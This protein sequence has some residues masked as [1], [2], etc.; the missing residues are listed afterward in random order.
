MHLY[1]I[2]LHIHSVLR[3]FVL[4]FVILA[5]F[6]SM[7]G[8]LLKYTYNQLDKTV[9][10][11]ALASFHLQV[12][13]GILLYFLSPKI[14][15]HKAMFHVEMLRF[16]TIEHSSMMILSAV[17]ITIGYSRS[18]KSIG[19]DRKGHQQIL[20]FYLVALLIVLWAIPWPCKEALGGRWF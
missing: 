10:L 14:L 18:K 17:L 16:F 7:K 13:L 20:I 3:Y 4:L 19:I 11:V 2:V 9:A 6:N 5:V 1:P 15:F 12:F 8:V